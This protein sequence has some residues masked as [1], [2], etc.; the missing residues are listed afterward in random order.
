MSPP[1]GS[2]ALHFVDDSP[3][4]GLA[5]ARRPVANAL[6]TLV[7]VHGALDRAG[8]FGRLTRRLERFNVVA[9]DRR[10]Y[11]GSRDLGAGTLDQHVSDLLAVIA[12]ESRHGPVAVLGHSFGGL[13]A[14]GAAVEAP[15]SVQLVTAFESPFPW[16]VRRPGSAPTSSE[17][18]HLEA[19]RFFRRVVSDGAWLRLSEAQRSSR[20]EDGPALLA[21]LA[22]LHGPRP[23]DPGVLAVPS[24]YA[25]GTGAQGPHY[26]ELARALASANPL[27]RPVAVPGASHAA[28]LSRPDALARVVNEAWTERCAS[29]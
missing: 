11:Q 4:V 13:V 27:I 8:S 19:E 23:F 18:P 3:V 7:C 17:D 26:A 9:Y 28:H 5:L 29:A 12:D 10:G 15:A 21:D 6:A 1:R 24:I 22:A 20:R 14:L 16:L 25:Y 2:G